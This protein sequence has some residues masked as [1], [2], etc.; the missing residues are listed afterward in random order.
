[1][2]PIVGVLLK[3]GRAALTAFKSSKLLRIL[4]EGALWGAGFSAVEKAVSAY[5]SNGNDGSSQS[6]ADI[7]KSVDDTN[8]VVNMVKIYLPDYEYCNNSVKLIAMHSYKTGFDSYL[9]T[10]RST[11]SRVY[12]DYAL[13]LISTSTSLANK[14]ALLEWTAVL[15][16]VTEA[17][18]FYP[19]YVSEQ[20]IF[21]FVNMRLL[22]CSDLI[23]TNLTDLAKS[24]DCDPN[25]YYEGWAA[26]VEALVKDIN[27][28]KSSNDPKSSLVGITATALSV[29]LLYVTLKQM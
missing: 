16:F 29:N 19:D 5:D 10:L 12:D 23:K 3:A 13:E 11:L 15:D 2:L 27:I 21:N 1:M 4:G 24:M 28:A 20:G 26:V 25:E 22:A 8:D 6:A 9:R 18:N 17:T 7:Q 14:R